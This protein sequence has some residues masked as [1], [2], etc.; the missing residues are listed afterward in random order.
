MSIS[1]TLFYRVVKRN[2]VSKFTLI[3]REALFC[4]EAFRIH[5]QFCDS[6]SK[7]IRVALGATLDQDSLQC[8]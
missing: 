3:A 8:P 5:V 4:D 6:C 1:H 7:A 2:I